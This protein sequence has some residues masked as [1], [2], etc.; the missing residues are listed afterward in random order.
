M[1]CFL[2]SNPFRYKYSSQISGWVNYF[3]LQGRN[4]FAIRVITHELKYLTWK[5]AYLCLSNEEL[6]DQLR[7]KYC[8]LIIGMCVR[9]RVCV[10]AFVRVCVCAL[11]SV[12]IRDATIIFGFLNCRVQASVHNAF[13]L[14]FEALF[15]DV[16]ENMSVLDR[17]NLTFV[18]D[19]I[20]HLGK[21]A[22][23]QDN[24][25]SSAVRTARICERSGVT[26]RE[27]CVVYSYSTRNWRS[28]LIC[29]DSS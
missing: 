25:V 23:E 27:M 8:H 22:E 26:M 13:V 17:I 9:V 21:S 20:G 11:S 15:V 10:C 4:E 3:S 5:E 14:L 29:S 18:Y 1:C 28:Q 6:P 24:A 2:G 7:A 12:V 16:G 19:E